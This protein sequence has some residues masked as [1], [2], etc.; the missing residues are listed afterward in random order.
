[1][2]A[3]VFEGCSDGSMD[4]KRNNTRTIPLNK[5]RAPGNLRKL[6]KSDSVKE[7]A[8]SIEQFGMLYPPTV[9]KATG[10]IIAG[11]SRVAAHFLLKRTNIEVC[12]VTVE[13]M[14]ARALEI[15]ENLCRRHESKE[16]QTALQLEL[17]KIYEQEEAAKDQADDKTDSKRAKGNKRG[18]KA[19]PRRRAVKRA[20]EATGKSVAAVQRSVQRA[21]E[22]ERTEQQEKEDVAEEPPVITFGLEVA[23]EF[24]LALK[25]LQHA[26][27]V[28]YANFLEAQRSM[29]RLDKAAVPMQLSTREL[30]RTWQSVAAE[31]KGERPIAICPGCK[32]IETLTPECSFCLGAGY[33]TEAQWPHV[34]E[35]LQSQE[36]LVVQT[37][38]PSG[39]AAFVA[40]DSMFDYEDTED[41]EPEE[42]PEEVP[43]VEPE[44]GPDLSGLFTLD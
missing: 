28:A 14:H 8:E 5:L 15:V 3:A 24:L 9:N 30:R 31:T 29:T 41:T 1:M 20:A 22:E 43:D 6:L 17:V 27:D 32:L 33:V 13:Q 21:A 39:N 44:D 35:A 4:I 11:R 19:S 42:A 23:P 7:L 18:P 37:G 36:H 10:E 2:L 26:I 38:G 12:Y 16:K 40:Y 34:P 25:T